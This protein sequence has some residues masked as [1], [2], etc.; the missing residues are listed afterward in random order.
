MEEA[1]KKSAERGAYDPTMLKGE[2]KKQWTKSSIGGMRQEKRKANVRVVAIIAILV[3]IA[4]YL[5][6]ADFAGLS[7]LYE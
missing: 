7:K 2:F 4:Y 5:M 1:A 3:L 6:K